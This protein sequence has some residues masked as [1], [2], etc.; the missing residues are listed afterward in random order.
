MRSTRACAAVVLI[1]LMNVSGSTRAAEPSPAEAAQLRETMH[2][3]FD[4]LAVVLPLSLDDEKFASTAERAK[5]EGALKT[6]AA[7]S[8]DVETHTGRRDA[9]FGAISQS[10][11]RDIDDAQRHFARHHYP[12]AQFAISQLTSN[13]V[14]CHSRLPKAQDFPLAK[15]LTDMPELQQL[16]PVERVRL[17]VATR[18][19]DAALSLCESRMADPAIPPVDLDMD[20]ELLTYLVVSV[21]VQGDL[22]RAHAALTRF[23]A[24]TDVPLYLSLDLRSWLVQLAELGPKKVSTPTLAHAREL[25]ERGRKLSVFPADRVGLV[26]DLSA[27]SELMRF[28][29]TKPP[30]AELAEAYFLLGA[31]AARIERSAWVSETEQDLETSIRIDPS[32]PFAETAYALLEEY[33][34]EAFGGSEGIE[35][36]PDVEARLRE[37]R[38]LVVQGRGS[39]K[40]GK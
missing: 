14:A 38:A 40:K 30:K 9:G 24:R 39:A 19:F 27:S 18:Q 10:L 26:Y 32:G 11:A 13:C 8:H 23:A 15:K 21:R 28:V 17:L 37:L 29:G 2:K 20:G 3:V 31:I 22:A 5:I 33:T 6:L 35:V 4:A 1:V 34:F 25:L 7:Q 12:E 36:P 16:E